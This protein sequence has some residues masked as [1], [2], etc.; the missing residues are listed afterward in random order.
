MD[1]VFEHLGNVEPNNVDNVVLLQQAYIPLYQWAWCSKFATTMTLVNMCIIHGCSNM[2]VNALFSLLHK[3]ILPVDNCLSNSM[4]G[5]KTLC[6]RIGLEY[7]KI[8]AC[9]SRCVL[10]KGQYVGHIQYP[11]CGSARYKQVGRTQVPMKVVRHFPIIPWL[12]R[13]YRS[14]TML[15]LL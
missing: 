7:N 2:F 13:M 8:H 10:Y 15:E 9:I 3:F 4:Y 6:Q 11:K 1:L 5:V 14:T 12:K